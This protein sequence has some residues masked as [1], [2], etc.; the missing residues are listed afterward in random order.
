VQPAAT[1]AIEAVANACIDSLIERPSKRR[2]DATLAA[3]FMS[4]PDVT[5]V[6]PWRGLIKR[7]SAQPLPPAVPVFLAQG[8]AD[9][10]V[11]PAVTY[12]FAQRLCA[13]G[14]HLQLTVLPGT[15]HGWIAMRTAAAAVDWMGN[16]FAGIP[17][18]DNCPQLAQ[19]TA[20]ATPASL[21]R[22]RQ[23]GE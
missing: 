15:G 17:T 6:E 23:R 10:I 5:E 18:P 4:V 13:G 14:S 3:T 7:N 19:L 16:R 11:R 2:A 8:G 22:E 9:V 1:P 21:V 20:G 12:S